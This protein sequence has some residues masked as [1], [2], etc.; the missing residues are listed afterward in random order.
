MTRPSYA[1]LNWPSTPPSNGRSYRAPGY[2]SGPARI[3]LWLDRTVAVS[4][5]R[6][7][8]DPCSPPFLGKTSSTDGPKAH[9]LGR[10]WNSFVMVG[11][12]STLLGLVI[13]ASPRLYSSFAA[14][15]MALGTQREESK[16]KALYARLA[17]VDF[18]SEILA[19]VPV[20][21]TVLPVRGVDWSDLGE[22]ARVMDTL[23]R[24]GLKSRC[25]CPRQSKRRKFRS[26]SSRQR[27]KSK[28]HLA[29]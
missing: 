14:I 23:V 1:T 29:V 3:G 5:P 6:Q 16:V 27:T 21:L 19:K 9:G 24:L 12:V 18:S 11:R 4:V 10:R 28:R 25:R 2:N 22:P 13:M 7:F 15:R 26:K 17:A 20:N 8:T